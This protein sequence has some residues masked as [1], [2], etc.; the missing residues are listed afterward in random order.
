VERMV[1][2]GRVRMP[3]VE[4]KPPT[5]VIILG[6]GKRERERDTHRQTDRQT[7]R[8]RERERVMSLI[9]INYFK[10]CE[11]S[12]FPGTSQGIHPRVY[13]FYIFYIPALIVW[14]RHESIQTPSYSTA[15]VAHRLLKR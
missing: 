8:Q 12:A 6:G 2:Q 3:T 13:I 5:A 9:V 10:R 15:W 7:D 11:T 4:L 1:V 14:V